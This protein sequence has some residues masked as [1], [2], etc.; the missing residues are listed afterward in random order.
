M[1]GW[2]GSDEHWINPSIFETFPYQDFFF[3]YQEL[4]ISAKFPQSVSAPFSMSEYSSPLHPPQSSHSS[5]GLPPISVLLTVLSRYL[6]YSA[7]LSVQTHLAAVGSHCIPASICPTKF[8]LYWSI[9]NHFKK[10]PPW[11]CPPATLWCHGRGPPRSRFFQICIIWTQCCSIYIYIFWLPAPPH[12]WWFIF[13]SGG[14]SSDLFKVEIGDM[15]ASSFRKIRHL[16]LLV[17]FW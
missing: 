14:N 6:S 11:P 17:I 12:T 4:L 5:S 8:S 9:L 7:S 2:L 10:V 3:S 13:S 15:S 16:S 1:P